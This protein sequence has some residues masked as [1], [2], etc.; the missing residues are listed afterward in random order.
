M[1]GDAYAANR[2]NDRHPFSEYV[3][4]LCGLFLTLFAVAAYRSVGVLSMNK[5]GYSG[6][7]LGP[8]TCTPFRGKFRLRCFSYNCSLLIKREFASVFAGAQLTCL[9]R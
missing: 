6:A 4:L 2:K 1:T 5:P 3:Q 9:P 7:D 8:V